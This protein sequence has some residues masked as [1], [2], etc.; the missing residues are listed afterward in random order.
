MPDSPI[1]KYTES[2]DF[3]QR[4]SKQWVLT[5]ISI[6]PNKETGAKETRTATFIQAKACE[7]WLASMGEDHNIYFH[8]NPCLRPLTKK[9]TRADIAALAW[10]HVDVDP[11]IGKD[12]KAEQERAL[13]LLQ[14]PQGTVPPP[15]VIIF[16]GG[17]YQGFWKLAS[18]LAINGIEEK[19]EEAKRYN[20]QLELV[21]EADNCHNVDRIMRLPGTINWPDERKR[22][23]G[24]TPVVAK[25]VEWHEE[26]VYNIREFRQSQQVQ[27]SAGNNF[28]NL[29]IKITG[30]LARLQSLD[31]LPSGVSMLCKVVINNGNDPDDLSRF[32]SRSEALFFVCCELT[33]A[34]MTADQVYAIITDPDFL[35]SSSVIDKGV[36]YEKYAIRQISRAQENAIDPRL[37]EMN[38]RHAVIGNLGGRCRVVEEVWDINLK[39]S[40]LIKQT[41]EDVRNRYGNIKIKV[42]T[43]KDGAELFMPLGKWWLSNE[44]RRQYNSLVFSPGKAVDEDYNLWQGFG[45]EAVEGI[46][47]QSFLD[48][49]GTNVCQGS[50]ELYNYLIGWLARIVQLPGEQGHTAIV[51]R[52]DQG[53]GKGFLARTIGTLFGRHYLHVSN[54]QH[55][56]GNFNAHLRDCVLLFADEAFYAGDKKHA[57]VLKTLVTEDALMV[58]LKGVDSE[59]AQNCVHLIMASNDDWVVPAGMHERRFFVCDVSSAKMQ[60]DTYFGSISK[61]LEAGG[62]QHLLQFLMD[63]DISS[64]NVRKIPQTRA[65]Q[66]QKI[67]SFTPEEEWWYHK[68]KEG[69]IFAQK[70]EWPVIVLCEEL[71]FDY[72]E[73]T[74][75]YAATSRGNATKL[76]RFLRKCWPNCERKQLSGNVTADVGGQK[77][78]LDRPYAYV[79]ETLEKMR[80]YWDMNYGGP[81]IWPVA[82]AKH[83]APGSPF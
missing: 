36:N 43:T 48:H 45:V 49:L 14:T 19:Y 4:W 32:S 78:E 20:Q 50:E 17:G 23:K 24:R 65:L 72:M 66:E 80:A 63:Y 11:R 3:L 68:L 29:G 53:V 51:L 27:L 62:F 81:F 79:L 58:E 60:N 76:G 64:F 56:T 6:E 9:A 10:L 12:L 18:H 46:L 47:H 39:R 28:T 82:P 70:F 5:A 77:K 41:F 7:A 83:I 38:D 25:L 54:A 15:T 37:M 21:F 33:R 35:I 42:G 75:S 8:V 31:D 16:S 26:R 74:K 67:Y 55:L 73:Y 2:I 30:N 59:M 1:P 71:L 34:G 40:R 44:K 22:K 13:T 57:S 52:G 69:R 61:D